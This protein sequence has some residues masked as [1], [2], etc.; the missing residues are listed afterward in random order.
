MEGTLEE[1]ATNAYRLSQATLRATLKRSFQDSDFA[2]RF[3]NKESIY[4]S[5]D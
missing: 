1:E 5:F 2:A 3:E 4:R